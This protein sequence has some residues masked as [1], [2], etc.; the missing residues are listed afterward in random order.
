ME[1]EF[2]CYMACMHAKMPC[3][4]NHCALRTGD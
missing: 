3:M 1:E 4:R 2:Q